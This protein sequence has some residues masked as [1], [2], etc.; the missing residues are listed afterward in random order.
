M[1][2]PARL[3]SLQR[4]AGEPCCG[5]VFAAGAS[6]KISEFE[7]QARSLITNLLILLYHSYQQTADTHD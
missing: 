6:G 5:K 7:S 3:L 2:K 1:R 4:V